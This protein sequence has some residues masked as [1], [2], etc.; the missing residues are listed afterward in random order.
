MSIPSSKRRLMSHARRSLMVSLPTPHKDVV[1][2]VLAVD[3]FVAFV[4]FW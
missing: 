3:S 1:S 4:Q 2:F